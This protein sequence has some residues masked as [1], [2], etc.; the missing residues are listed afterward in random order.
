MGLEIFRALATRFGLVRALILRDLLARHGRHSLGFFWD[1]M[2]PIVLATGV[3]IIWSVV[4]SGFHQVSI[5][6]LAVAC[7]LP[8]TLSRHLIGPLT[9][10]LR[11]NSNLLFHR[12]ITAIEVITA[13]IISEFLSSTSALI[14]IYFVTVN[15]GVV[16][17]IENWPLALLGW[18]FTGWFYGG[19]ALLACA[20]TEIWDPAEKFIPP[21]QYLL[22]PL[23][24]AFFMIDWVPS[25]AQRL[26]LLN[27]AVH[28]YEIFR[29][30]FFGDGIP[31]HYSLPY[32]TAWSIGLTLAGMAAIYRVRDR[33]QIS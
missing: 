21:I 4:E 3:M 26:L 32:L 14:L 29:A 16:D 30:G 2:D 20:W 6:T 1:I 9:R 12:Q 13:R 23:S 5:T 31:A 19:M 18:L 8:L 33:I 11:N 10:L 15:V 17:P 7:Y 24:A 22:M 25:H 28:C 27:P